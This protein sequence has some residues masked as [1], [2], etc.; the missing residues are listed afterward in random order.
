MIGA[1]IRNPADGTYLVLKRS[2]EK[3][4]G[5]GAWEC[6]TG[7]VDQ[8]EGFTDAVRREVR[9]ELD[10]EAYI[11]FIVG[12][13]HFYRGE[14]RPEN[15]MV[16]VVYCCTVDDPGS[17]RTSWEHAQRRWVTAAE[18]TKLF[19]EPHWLGRLIRRAEE[20]RALMPPDL[21][22]YYRINGFDA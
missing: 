13:A 10:A 5:A 1:L 19:P 15:E 4:V 16:G 14:A 6:V 11:E 3:D 21:L 2:V 9:E 12:T 8:G 20:L 7:R 22:A 18:A 17:I